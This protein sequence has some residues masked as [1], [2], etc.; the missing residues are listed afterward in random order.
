MK[1]GTAGGD[2]IL[3]V[4]YHTIVEENGRVEGVKNTREN[5][6]RNKGRRTWKMVTV[7]S[8]NSITAKMEWRRHF[9]NG[10]RKLKRY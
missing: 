5:Y 6:F 7:T 8:V 3:S 9:E 1:H 4:I 10:R 2:G